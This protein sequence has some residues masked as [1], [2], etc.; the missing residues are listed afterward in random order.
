M[1]NI[2]NK[3]FKKSNLLLKIITSLFLLLAL[4]TLFILIVFKLRNVLNSDS[5][6]EIM[7]GKEV[8][9]YH[10]IFPKEWFYS[11]EIRVLNIHLLIAAFLK[12]TNQLLVAKSL[13]NIILMI[14]LASSYL[15]FMKS[16][17][18]RKLYTLIFLAALLTPFSLTSMDMLFAG[19]FYTPY[20][21]CIF[22]FLAAVNFICKESIKKS[23]KAA[24][25]VFS[26]FIAFACG[27]T[28]TRYILN[29]FIPFIISEIFVY[30]FE[31]KKEKNI[32]VKN[33]AVRYRLYISAFFTFVSF[34]GFLFFT[35][36]LS[37]ELNFCDFGKQQLAVQSAIPSRL[38][39]VLLSMFSL[40]GGFSN[41]K[42]FSINGISAVSN[43]F[44][45]LIL[46]SIFIKLIK[47]IDNLSSNRKSLILLFLISTLAN[48]YILTITSI[49][50]LDRYHI[51]SLLLLL[52]IAGVFLDEFSQLFSSLLRPLLIVFV[53]ISMLLSQYIYMYK[54]AINHDYNINIKPVVSYLEDNNLA[55]GYSTFWNNNIVQ[56]LSNGKIELGCL[57]DSLDG[58]PYYWLTPDRIYK[59][60]Y[61]TGKTFLLL[62]KDEEKIANK[63]LLA[64]GTKVKEINE[65]CIYI[66]DINPLNP[67]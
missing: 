39:T 9:R 49:E 27:A 56:V 48:V 18:V 34:V 63:T 61:H 22:S 13:S 28:G 15:F 8:L 26:C 64:K 31:A 10:S 66:Y 47:R 62:T 25:I 29:L 17:G 19:A 32:I 53:F 21:I 59:K 30:W 46:I 57:K 36:V 67:N 20:L 12:F 3:I 54:G 58:S 14:L 2:V 51:N 16:L 45:F 44:F 60:D 42:I 50:I 38:Q 41:Y 5:A 7:L 40:F 1:I 33:K 23:T 35:L 6:S 65:Y 11:S 55:F 4:S 24:L 52:P 37:K 43:L